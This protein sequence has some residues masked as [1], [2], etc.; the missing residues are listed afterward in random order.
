MHACTCA[1][2][3]HIFCKQATGGSTALQSAGAP[4]LADLDLRSKPTASAGAAVHI[5]VSTCVHDACE[6]SE[7]MRC[8]A[9]RCDARGWNAR[10]GEAMRGDARHRNAMRCDAM[11]A[12]TLVRASEHLFWLPCW[13]QPRQH[14]CMRACVCA[15][16]RAGGRARECSWCMHM[17]AQTRAV[18]APGLLRE[19]R[20][21]FVVPLPA[22]LGELNLGSEEGTNS[23]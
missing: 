12:C 9:R 2:V 5:C 15:C 17:S 1:C 14:L 13:L 16:G 3:N 21:R 11:Q 6:R 10:K 18:C 8:E 23:P 19:S 4:L 20:L 7:A 22:E